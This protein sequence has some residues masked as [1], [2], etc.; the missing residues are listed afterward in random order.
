[1]K[2]IL[3]SLVLLSSNNLLA[4]EKI[5]YGDDNRVDIVKVRSQKIQEISKAVAGRISNFSFSKNSDDGLV[6]KFD[7]ILKL[8]DEWSMNVCSDEKFANQPTVADC[9][10]FLVGE[11]L[12]VTAGHCVLPAGAKV[13]DDITRGCVSNSWIFDY[14]MDKSGEIDLE[15]IDKNNI[16][17]C[18][19]VIKGKYTRDEDYA[20]IELDRKVTDRKPLTIRTSGKVS[21]EETLFVIGH[22][23]GL[24][25]KF[26]D[27]AKV[28]ETQE[29]YFGTNLDTFGGNSGSPVF[30]AK[31]LEVEGILV[32]GDVDYVTTIFD[33]KTCNRVNICDPKRENCIEDDEDIVGEHVTYIS[34]ILSEIK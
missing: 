28:F 9:T 7:D 17:G 24:P 16:V 11:N 12:L 18:K 27:G 14:K 22:P 8:S 32:R 5:V 1:M 25:Q 26:A 21:V 23:S 34:K 15:H 20:L 31:T 13:E 4:A 19:R 10:G 2:Y 3:V 33:G 30:N 6:I 29:H